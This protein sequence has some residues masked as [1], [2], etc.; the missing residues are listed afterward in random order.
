MPV[1]SLAV[2]ATCEQRIEHFQ[3]IQKSCSSSPAKNQ[4]KDLA[5]LSEH[6]LVVDCEENFRKNKC[7]ELEKSLSKADQSKIAKCNGPTL[8]KSTLDQIGRVGLGCVVGG[9]NFVLGAVDSVLE[10]AKSIS[11]SH[12]AEQECSAGK[13]NVQTK[14]TMFALY[15]DSVPEAL[16]LKIPPEEALGPMRCADIK[17]RLFDAHTFNVRRL[18]AEYSVAKKFNKP[19]SQDLEDFSQWQNQRINQ[20]AGVQS[21]LVGSAKK[22][23]SEMGIKLSCYDEKAVTAMLCEAAITGAVAVVPGSSV[24][25]ASRARILKMAGI[26]DKEAKSLRATAAL[27]LQRVAQLSSAERVK[28]AESVLARALSAPER[29][30]LLKAHDVG[31]GT[32]RGIVASSDGTIDLARS[33]YSSADLREKAEILKKAGFSEADR[34]VLMRRGLAGELADAQAAR[35]YANKARLQA[36]K[37]RIEGKMDEASTSYRSAADS[38]DAYLNDLKIQKTDRDYWVGAELNS[39][40][41]RYD[42]AAEYLIKS[43]NS[44]GSTDKKAQ[45]I[46]ESLRR[47]KEE[48]RITAGR[49]S[50]NLGT[51]KAYE[52]HLKLIEAVVKSPSL[53]MGDVWKRELL[54][55]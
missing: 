21:D 3:L 41:G 36:D 31:A 18:D 1:A 6:Q 54:K 39:R 42:K 11:E 15:N 43:N 55:P 40:A 19:I 53:R 52:D 32:G 38:Y 50:G 29:D 16:R 26:A 35:T 8:C 25:L 49:N 5:Q 10:L 45:A 27:D 33:T 37:L 20:A 4:F 44:A 22:M 2:D 48:L 51:K 23:L 34:E 14:Q 13:D 7:D 9:K 24:L 17:S 47:E 30:A 28:E 12:A 46:F